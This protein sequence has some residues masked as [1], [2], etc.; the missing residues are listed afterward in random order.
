MGDTSKRKRR[1]RA[2]SQNPIETG[3][4]V[5]R[6]TDYSRLKNGLIRQPVFSQDKLENVHQTALRVLQELGIRVLHPAA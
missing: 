5:L 1:T 3:G 6:K 4:A 2:R